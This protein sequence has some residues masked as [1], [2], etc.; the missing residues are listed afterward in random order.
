MAHKS[1]LGAP[2]VDRET[3][4]LDEGARFLSATLGYQAKADTKF[5]KY[6]TL[7][8]RRWFSFES[9]PRPATYRVGKP[10]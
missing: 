7:F 9:F 6:A 8:A 5:P 3:Y 4:N 2:V 1:R 10:R